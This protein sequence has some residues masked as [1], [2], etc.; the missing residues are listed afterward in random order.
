MYRR[1]LSLRLDAAQSCTRAPG[2][3]ALPAAPAAVARSPNWLTKP[4]RPHFIIG[5]LA[6]AAYLPGFW[7]GAPHATAPELTHSWGVDDETPLGPLA[8]VHGILEPKDDQNLG[9]PLLHS[10]LLAAAYTPYLGYLYV[11]GD[12]GTNQP[13]YPF[14]LAR[15]V[16]SLRVLTWIAHLVS[17]FLAACVVVAAYASGR[18]LWGERTG[19]IGALFVLFSFPMF[20]YSRTGNIDVPALFFIALSLA[21]YAHVMVRGFSIAS[22]TLL[23]CAAGLAVATKEPSAA[24]L[25]GLP[26]VLLPIHKQQTELNYLRW[27]FWKLPLV[28]AACAVLAFGIGSGLFIS[29]SW[30]I[31]HLV[32]VSERLNAV[33]SGQVAFLQDYPVGWRGQLALAWAI[34]DRVIDAMT[35]PGLVLALLGVGYTL[36]ARDRRILFVIPS[37]T[38]LAALF[39]SARTVQLRYVMPAVFPLL[40]FAARA[41]VLGWQSQRR[42][43]R[44]AAIFVCAW[45][46]GLGA[47]RA[48]D[49]THGM[50]KD[51]RYAAG[52]WLDR[53]VLAGASL[54]Y[55][56]ASQKLPRLNRGVHLRRAAS[57]YGAIYAVRDDDANV[58]EII[59]GWQERR[60]D[61]IV[62]IPDHSSRPGAPHSA[63]CPPRVYEKLLDGSLGYE[64][65]A[66]FQTPRLFPWLPKPELDYPTV[67]PP[68]R[69]F[70]R[71][72]VRQRGAEA[73]HQRESVLD[74]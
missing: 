29:P 18:S 11:T 74:V 38:Y 34:T 65:V 51:S 22:A 45:I 58:V 54:E 64:L 3:S 21:I 49:L 27:D 19:T 43:V 53:Q 70:A 60:P 15:P 41:V 1:A 28:S 73:T 30:Y 52:A 6:L 31:R 35:L 2:S 14:G 48:I 12:L 8:Q 24:S 66:F 40:L 5:L 32:F 17:V 63:S 25:V 50:I 55:F 42:A 69:V 39:F 26:F 47:L 20:Y 57:Y 13:S 37:V 56:G 36:L 72:T 16:E 67:N 62:I 68:I 44:Y 33:A 23:G 7:W 10:F 46:V 59:E 9:Y 71:A 61:F 4:W